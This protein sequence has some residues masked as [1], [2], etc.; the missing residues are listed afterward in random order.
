M[1]DAH[2]SVD[3]L[4][5]GGGPAG[6]AAGTLLADASLETLL[7]E[8]ESF[9]RFH[10]GESLLPHTLPLLDR[11]GVHDEV[12]SLPNTR[13]KAGA[14]FVAGDGNRQVTYWY[15]SAL[16]QAL[17]YAYQ[18]RRDEFDA[19]LLANARRR[20]VEVLEGWTAVAPVWEGDRLKGLNV[21]DPEGSQYL[22]SCRALLDASGHSAFLASRMGWRFPYQRRQKVAILSHFRGVLLPLGRESGNI[23]IIT[24]DDGWFW[25]L[26][27]AG[28]TVSVG[29]VLDLARWRSAGGDPEALF[30]ASIAAT[31][32]IARR[33]AR[34]KAVRPFSVIQNLSFR[35][36][37]IAGPGYCL[38]GD[39]A[40]FLEPVFST[41][42]FLAIT[43]AVSAAE[44]IID[45]LARHRRVEANDF[46]PTV[47]LTRSLH[48]LFFSLIRSFNDP[49]FLALFFAPPPFLNLAGALGSLLAGNVERPG[50]WRRIGRYRIFQLLAKA[51]RVR[52]TSKE[53]SIAPLDGPPPPDR[54][55]AP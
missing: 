39:A 29:A 49:H 21:R 13:Q 28:D 54:W 6:S 27:F 34:A 1:M 20:G 41:G 30:A 12:R 8:R 17:P 55:A 9:P 42:V 3:V 26:P 45:A 24:G 37:R 43:T 25:V 5:L 48:R 47:A 10:E 14:T 51:Q 52:G 22:V 32:E 18:V 7:I 11:L 46:A 23:T 40:G 53:P 19:V 35:V 16:P 44:D 36:N 38:I 50:M 2:R 4:V 15:D 31:P 33:M